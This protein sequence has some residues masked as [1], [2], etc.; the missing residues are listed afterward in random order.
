MDSEDNNEF[1][2]S[3]DDGD[4]CDDCSDGSYGLDY[5]GDGACDAGDGDDDNDGAADEV[6]SDDNNEFVCSDDDGDTCDDCSDGSYGLDDDGIDF[7]ADGSCDAGDGA[8][9]GEV[10]LAFE[11]VTVNSADLVYSSD[12]DIYGYQFTVGGV[13]LTGVEDGPFDGLSFS[14]SSGTVVAFSFSGAFLPAGEGT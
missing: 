5:D 12:V 13:T 11:N 9:W 8:P 3:D 7:D 2:C 6:D 14:A 4:T 10:D 1:V